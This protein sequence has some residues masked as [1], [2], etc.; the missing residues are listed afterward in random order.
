MKEKVNKFC[1]KTEK[2]GEKVSDFNKNV[3]DLCAKAGELSVAAN[4]I[5]ETAINLCEQLKKVT[6]DVDDSNSK[7]EKLCTDGDEHTVNRLL[8]KERKNFDTHYE[9]I[10]NRLP[11]DKQLN[12]SKEEKDLCVIKA[13]A[14]LYANNNI[15]FTGQ[16]GSI[17]LVAI[18]LFFAIYPFTV[19]LP[20]VGTGGLSSKIAFGVFIALSMVIIFSAVWALRTL[21]TAGKRNHNYEQILEICKHINDREA[22]SVKDK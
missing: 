14:R 1:E 15:A 6:E 8:Y 7:V 21:I 3:Q 12:L 20:H 2:F 19:F 18:A 4:C 22:E 16:V 9:M 5:N 11:A 10:R 13:G 17:L